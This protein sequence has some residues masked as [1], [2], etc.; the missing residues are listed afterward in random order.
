MYPVQ[1]LPNGA[2]HV[3]NY[4]VKLKIGEGKRGNK[5]KKREDEDGKMAKKKGGGGSFSVIRH[6][7][8]PQWI[9]FTQFF[10]ISSMHYRE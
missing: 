10:S 2:V 1:N 8:G 3:H 9:K 7:S 6:S 5:G 4:D